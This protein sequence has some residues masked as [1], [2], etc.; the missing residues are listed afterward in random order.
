[1]YRNI[2]I[3]RMKSFAA[4]KK[5]K[6]NEITIELVIKISQGIFLLPHAHGIKHNCRK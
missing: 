2:V 6:A 1:M 5:R 3:L 4:C